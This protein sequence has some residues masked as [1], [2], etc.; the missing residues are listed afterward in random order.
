MFGKKKK[1]IEKSKSTTDE[2]LVDALC[3]MVKLLQQKLEMLS[4][5]VDGIKT[6]F[7]KKIPFNKDEVE[8]EETKDLSKGMLLPSESGV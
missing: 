1:E 7:K 6:R 2:D 5:D 3:K 4:I 8:T